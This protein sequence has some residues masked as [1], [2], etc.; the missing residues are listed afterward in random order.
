[1]TTQ[2]RPS[3]WTLARERFVIELKDFSRSTEQ[4]IFVF[5]FP[6]ILLAL[7]SAMLGKQ[8][9]G[10][11]G[12]SFTQYLLG[13]IVASA[14][15]YTGFQSPAMA[16]AIDRD[17]DVL[18]RL[19]ATPLP[20]WAFFVGKVGQVFAVTLVQVALLLAIGT[21]VYR[22]DLP[23][24]PGQWLTLGWLLLLGIASSTALG[25]AT[26]SLLRNG[27][28]ASAVLTP[29]V[30]VLQFI[31]GVFYVYTQIPGVL[32]GIAEVFPLKWLALGMRSF[33]LPEG[34]E[35]AE[36]R[37]S[38]EHGTTAIMLIVWLVIGLVV[39]LRTFRWQR[40]DDK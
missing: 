3:N 5:A 34:F 38:W 2:A 16:I 31:S 8:T 23:T 36:S 12:V 35:T 11:T 25:L 26:S 1:M 24:D 33:F 4:M 17:Q 6:F 27:K 9:L 29:L 10:D 13:G 14:V 22:I 15:I 39:A 21:F 18:K 32:Q 20:S 7:L 37:G 40:S 30:L 28:A 19:R